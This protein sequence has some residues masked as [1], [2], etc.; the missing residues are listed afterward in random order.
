MTDN[1]MEHTFGDNKWYKL[2]VEELRN[3]PE[4][5]QYPQLTEI[6]KAVSERNQYLEKYLNSILLHILDRQHVALHGG[7]R[8]APKGIMTDLLKTQSLNYSDDEFLSYY[9]SLKDPLFATAASKGRLNKAERRRWCELYLLSY[10]T[11][12]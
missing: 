12:K 3:Q 2:F 7:R 8:P 6:I 4:A 10:V 5:A 9:V 1:N 11:E